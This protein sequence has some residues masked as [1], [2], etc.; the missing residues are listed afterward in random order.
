VDREGIGACRGDGERAGRCNNGGAH[1][2]IQHV[3]LP[4]ASVH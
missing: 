1:G 2:P 4:G 3:R